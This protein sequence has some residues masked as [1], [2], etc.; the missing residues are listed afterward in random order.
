MQ[1]VRIVQYHKQSVFNAPFI[2]TD[3]LEIYRIDSNDIH[4]KVWENCLSIP[5]LKWFKLIHF[6]ER[7]PSLL[8]TTCAY[9]CLLI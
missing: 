3:Q 5:K 8:H 2:S 6:D 9:M 1:N 4:N 7:G